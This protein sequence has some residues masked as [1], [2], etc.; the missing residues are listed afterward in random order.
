M[1]KDVT[2][3]TGHE[4]YQLEVTVF[5][6]A[7]VPFPFQCTM[8]VIVQSLSFVKVYTSDIM[9]FF[10]SVKEQFYHILGMA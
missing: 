7:S 2:I 3:S 5:G 1:Q 10:G 8:E 6:L 4:S 9:A